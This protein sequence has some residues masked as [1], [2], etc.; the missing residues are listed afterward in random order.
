MPFDV[1]TARRRVQ[2]GATLLDLREPDWYTHIDEAQ[3]L[4][5]S[6]HEC[7]LGQLYE[8]RAVKAR[9]SGTP[10]GF[11]LKTLGLGCGND[12]AEYGFDVPIAT[13]EQGYSD[14]EMDMAHNQLADLWR[15]EIRRRRGLP[16]LQTGS[17]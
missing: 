9:Y 14:G 2:A 13:D 4:M 1:K 12:D 11:G 17:P 3:L 8:L 5:S 6:C 7:L 16:L 10:Y 15:V